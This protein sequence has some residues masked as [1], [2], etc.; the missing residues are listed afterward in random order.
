MAKEKCKQN[1]SPPLPHSPP[2]TS[3][4]LH[5][6]P[7][8]SFAT[9]CSDQRVQR[10]DTPPPPVIKATYTLQTGS[11][12]C[13]MFSP[14][15]RHPHLSFCQL[16]F[17]TKYCRTPCMQG[18]HYLLCV[19]SPH[20]IPTP[21]GILSWLESSALPT[22]K[23]NNNTPSH[24]LRSSPSSPPPLQRGPCVKTTVLWNRVGLYLPAL[25][26]TS[27]NSKQNL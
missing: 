27:H 5:T 17:C 6:K 19:C 14:L 9:I 20:P 25:L 3:G 8:V 12:A 7:A 2:A 11:S 13:H 16:S 10:S 24:P 18:W 15:P 22:R 26:L 23:K 1:A 21:D 4:V